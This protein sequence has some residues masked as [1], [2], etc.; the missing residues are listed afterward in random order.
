MGAHPTGF[1]I[2]VWHFSGIDLC[3]NSPDTSVAQNQAN[4]FGLK[5]LKALHMTTH[6]AKRE[7]CPLCSV[8]IWAT[9]AVLQ[10]TIVNIAVVALSGGSLGGAL[11]LPRPLT[12]IPTHVRTHLQSIMLVCPWQQ[13]RSPCNSR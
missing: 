12:H 1:S 9:S 8:N 6:M 3:L 13:G 4:V 2:L 5:A 11:F 10:L 7:S